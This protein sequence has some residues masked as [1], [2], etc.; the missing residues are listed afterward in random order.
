[1]TN[2]DAILFDLDDTLL[3]NDMDVFLTQYFPRI[4]SYVAPKIDQELFMKELLR[5]TQAMKAN[6]DS[7]KTN[8]DVFWEEFGKGTGLDQEEME[9][10]V[11]AFY[12]EKFGE[13]QKFTT[14]RPIASKI[15]Q[16]CFYHDLKVVI[17]TNPLFPRRAIDH[18]LDWAGIPVDKNAF[19][20]VTAYENMHS[21]KP[22]QSYY[23]EILDFITARP[24]RSM[25]VGDDW[26][27]DII[28]AYS[29][30][31]YTYLINP[32][33]DLPKDWKTKISGYG[34]LEDLYYRLDE[35]WLL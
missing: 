15:I 1:M 14:T 29:L 19:E 21:A 5:S 25:M 24:E 22:H 11:T 4:S 20:L 7:E 6:Q 32:G 27:N 9:P 10:F 16:L 34:S 2:L 30:G 28:P 3:G 18:H 35:G 33:D 23:V 17:A 31:M 13:L 26:E 12:E 8:R